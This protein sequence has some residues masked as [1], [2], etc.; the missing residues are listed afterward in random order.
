MESLGAA[1]PPKTKT[2]FHLGGEE[3]ATGFRVVEVLGFW[4]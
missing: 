1:R 3:K 4:G 2:R